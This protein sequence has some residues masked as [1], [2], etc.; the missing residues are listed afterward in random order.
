VERHK[1]SHCFHEVF[2]DFVSSFKDLLLGKDASWMS[3]QETEFLNRKG[4]L[5]QK[6]N[7]NVLMV[8]GSKENLAFLPCHIMNKMFV[9][10]IARQYN[11]WFHFFHEKKKKQ[12]IPL[13]WKVEDFVCRNI[14]NI[15]EFVRY[16]KKLN[17]MYVE[18]LKGFD[19]NGIFR[20]HLLA[21]SFSNSFIHRHL[22][23]DRDSE[24]NN[25]ASGNCDAETLQSATELYRKQGKVSSEK[26]S[27]S[28][29]S[30]PKSTTSRSITSMTHPSKKATQ[31]S[32]SEGGDKNP[33][34][35]K[36]DSSHKIPV[37]KKRKKNVG[38]AN[39]P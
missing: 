38:Q 2:N 3:S 11:H 28:P 1:A 7:H 22:T 33:T 23:E 19:P 4:T 29:A 30:T 36:I 17:L 21:V 39:E 37:T 13:P 32:S 27:Q 12:F 25:P 26:S 5:E 34:P 31:K 18:R 8:F 15:D 14:K 24:D 35:I 6:E 20:E 10:E 16:F 9:A